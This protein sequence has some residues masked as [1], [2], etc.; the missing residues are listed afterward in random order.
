MIK[1]MY[2][3]KIKDEVYILKTPFSIVWTGIVLISGKKNFLID[4]GADEPEKYIIP[5][6]KQMNM[7]ISDID[8]LLNTHC[9]GDHITGHHTLVNKYGL[10]TAVFDKAVP[11]L[12]NPAQNAVSIRTKFPKYSPAPQSWLKGVIADVILE[13]NEILEEVLYPIYT[14]GHDLDCVCWYHIPTKTIICGDSLQA[15][16]TPTQGIGFYRSLPS[17][18]NSLLKL[19]DYDIENIICGHDYDGIGSVILGKDNVRNALQKCGEYIGIYDKIIRKYAHLLEADIAVKL[20]NEAGCG[21]PENLF[22]SLY[23]VTEHL[24]EI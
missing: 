22:L 2:F 6:L 13:E 18:R 3:E 4:S 20:I 24:K 17:Y 10:K 16:G 19:Q 5:A 9:H 23:T 12:E 14:P 8:Y 1:Q 15:N 21:M 11:I 7:D